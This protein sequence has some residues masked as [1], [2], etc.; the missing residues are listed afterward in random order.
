MT[1]LEQNKNN[2]MDTNECTNVNTNY[3]NEI[4]ENEYAKRW[5]ANTADPLDLLNLSKQIEEKTGIECNFP[6]PQSPKPEPEWFKKRHQEPRM[7]SEEIEELKRGKG[8]Q[9]WGEGRRGENGR[10]TTGQNDMV[11]TIRAVE[12]KRDE[13]YEEI[14]NGDNDCDTTNTNKQTKD[15]GTTTK[16]KTPNLNIRLIENEISTNDKSPTTKM[17][18]TS[19]KTSNVKNKKVVENKTSTNNKS[20]TTEVATTSD[21]TPSMKGKKVIRNK[22]STNNESLMTEMATTSDKT[23]NVKCEKGIED[24][25]TTSDNN[26]KLTTKSATNSE[27]D[28][29]V[30]NETTTNTKATDDKPKLVKSKGKKENKVATSSSDKPPKTKEKTTGNDKV[31][32]TKCIE[33]ERRKEILAITNE[34]IVQAGKRKRKDTEQ[35]ESMKMETIEE[36]EN[37]IEEKATETNGANDMDWEEIEVNM[38]ASEIGYPTPRF[39]IREKMIEEER[40]KERPEIN[41]SEGIQ[42]LRAATGWEEIAANYPDNL[43]TMQPRVIGENIAHG[44]KFSIAAQIN[45]ISN[46]LSVDSGC[47]CNLI[48][49]GRAEE[50]KL[51][52]YKI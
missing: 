36:E 4:V 46:I 38:V 31:T 35:K 9:S 45:G 15:E 17:A 3:Y 18:T 23:P 19:E 33:N 52:K 5:L 30:K 28:W 29:E 37:Q 32:S 47:F 26:K 10:T 34:D 49:E 21:K 20:L 12:E 7:E 44:P 22:T 48:S 24:K 25:T 50:M 39:D 40:R 2:K 27:K 43:N 14:A 42:D 8:R 11:R 51:E 13:K 6:R 16:E 1:R 41:F